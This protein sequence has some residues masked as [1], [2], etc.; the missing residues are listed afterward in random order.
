MDDDEQDAWQIKNGLLVQAFARGLV[1][2]HLTNPFEEYAVINE[3][4]NDVMTILW[5]HGFSQTAIREAYEN[6]VED[7]PRYAAGQER[8]FDNVAD[9][10]ENRPS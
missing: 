4:L 6:A 3:L 2:Q 5:D 9:I 7:L 10:Y 1:R 8:R